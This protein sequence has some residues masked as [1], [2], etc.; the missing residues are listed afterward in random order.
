MR[1]DYTLLTPENVELHY[2]VAGVGSRVVAAI[3]DYIVLSVIYVVLLFASA[4]GA[5][6]LGDLARRAFPGTLTGEIV[7]NVV[8]AV[9]LLVMFLGLWGYFILFEV[10]WNGQSPG[11][12]MM[13]LRVVRTGGRPVTFIASLVRN[14]LRPV[15]LM[16]FIGVLIML[17]NRASRRLGDYAAGTLVVRDPRALRAAFTRVYLPNV[18]DE[19]I[20][21][22][23]NADRL[24]TEH[25]TLIRE[26]FSRRQHLSWDRA[27]ALE[28]VA[29]RLASDLAGLLE[30]PP[31][32]IGDPVLFLAAAAVAFERRH[33]YYDAPVAG[34]TV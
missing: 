28:P 30:I 23:V 16:L 31:Q 7:S 20:G 26:F 8:A 13:G 12:R 2:E 21:R 9:L 5:A 6:A 4:F 15:D 19:L 32:D 29:L 11:K 14:L 17:M 34:P 27:D 3:V 1:E 18:G 24:T 33:P 22:V 25:Y 10:M